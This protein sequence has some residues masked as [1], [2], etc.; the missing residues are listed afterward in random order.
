MSSTNHAD[1]VLTSSE[2]RC[3][4]LQPEMS[5]L[6]ILKDM[7]P[8]GAVMKED[9][10]ESDRQLSLTRKKFHDAAVRSTPLKRKRQAALERVPVFDLCVC[11]NYFAPP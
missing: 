7:F 8:C 5:G 10:N 9:S 2:S 4:I 3:L 11:D 1:S 6:L